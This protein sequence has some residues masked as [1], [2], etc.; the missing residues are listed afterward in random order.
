MTAQAIVKIESVWAKRARAL[1]AGYTPVIAATTSIL[2]HWTSAMRVPNGAMAA[3]SSAEPSHSIRDMTLQL[4]LFRLCAHGTEIAMDRAGHSAFT[5]S[6]HGWE[7][8]NVRR[9]LCSKRGL[10]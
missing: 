6:C 1:F 4:L 5:I 3:H 7:A 8:E 10:S 9:G 2:T